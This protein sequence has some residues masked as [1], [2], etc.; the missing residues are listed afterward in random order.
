[1][2]FQIYFPI[3]CV[4]GLCFSTVEV[5]SS[6]CY[7]RR[8]IVFS[9]FWSEMPCGFSYFNIFEQ[10]AMQ[11]LIFSIFWSEMPCGFSYFQYFGVKSHA[12]FGEFNILEWNSMRFLCFHFTKCELLLSI[13]VSKDGLK[14]PGMFTERL[15][16]NT[17][18]KIFSHRKPL[19]A[20]FQSPNNHL[21]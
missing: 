7:H 18:W 10:N 1:M 14:G 3:L 9:I 5:Q 15:F 20:C 17:L 2:Y 16:V 21:S 19:F 6:N 11:F 8:V 12:V 4:K 13:V